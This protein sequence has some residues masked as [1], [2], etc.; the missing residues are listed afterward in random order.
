[1]N[2]EIKDIFR[3]LNLLILTHNYPTKESPNSG[4]WIKRLWGDKP[5]MLIGKLKGMLGSL[6]KLRK[7]TGLII[8]YWIFPA[9]VLAWLSGRPYILNCV[10]LDIFIMN[11]SP[12]ISFLV[13]PI[14]KKAEALVF[15]GSHPMNLFHKIYKN[16][17][18]DKSHLIYLPVDSEEFN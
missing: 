9:G 4:I 15:I 10:G 2:S 7:E 3:D 14:L 6:L 18:K 17:F 1:M 11:R 13:K 5:V 16:E 12:L 8:A